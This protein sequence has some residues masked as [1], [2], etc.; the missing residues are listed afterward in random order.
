VAEFF[1]M[2]QASP[3]ME[4]GTLLSWKKAEGD[5]LAP[6]DVLAE[7]ETDKAAMEI[8]VFDSGYLLKI[9]AEEGD[10]IPAGQ[11]IA[12]LGTSADEDISDLMAK[13]E[14]LKAGAATASPATAP[15]APA[16][17]TPSAAPAPAVPTAPAQTGLQPFT[18]QGK[19]VHSSI[20]EMPN[21]SVGLPEASTPG[22]VA[23]GGKVRSSPA[24]RAAGRAKGIDL[25]RVQGTGP[26]GRVTRADVLRTAAGV[27]MPQAPA[28]AAPPPRAVPLPTAGPDDTVVRNSQMRKTI[29]KRLKAASSDAPV[30]FL[31]A[32]LD[33]D[34]LVDF[35]TKM[36]A[37]GVGVSY[38][39]IVIQACA[40]ALRDVP[41]V[42]AAWADEN[43]I[44]RGRV[45]IGVA[46]ALPGG[47]ITP[48]IRDADKKEL[49]D[50]SKE[51]RALAGR[52]R[53]QKLSPDEY[54][55][56]TFTISNLGMKKIDQFTAILNP[57]E[58]CILAVGAMRQ[59]P[60]VN[61]GKLAIG[62]RMKV[63]LT[64]DHRVVDGALGADFL[65]AM[66]SYIEDPGTL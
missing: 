4:T 37:E 9:L 27:P 64:C 43:I 6:Q 45:D 54:T 19:A 59:E 15:S 25:S 42:N 20:M 33:C 2:P 53:E 44:L 46:V 48:V 7:V 34:A 36:K 5:T 60:V 39:D 18:W 57:P 10:Q 65:A 1:E 31:T 12:I 32:T 11:P 51:I 50:I 47:L 29:A 52:A 28:P 21:F 24:A 49:P 13:Y 58:A 41:E 35:R 16:A 62:W 17:A 66:R 22:V 30:F 40:R 55:G 38:N 14:A 56:S 61:D 3:T 26:R 8:E 23:P 63:T